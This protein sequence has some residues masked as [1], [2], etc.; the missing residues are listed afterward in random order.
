MKLQDEVLR[1]G[2]NLGDGPGELIYG[3]EWAVGAALEEFVLKYWGDGESEEA[4]EG[5]GT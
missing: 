4:Q 2:R 3:D 1:N 5:D